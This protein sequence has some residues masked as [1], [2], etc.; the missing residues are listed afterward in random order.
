MYYTKWKD[1][2]LI[3]SV[4]VKPNR[5]DNHI[6]STNGICGGRMII[7]QMDKKSKLIDLVGNENV[8]IWIGNTKQEVR[9]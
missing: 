2:N 7:N 9:E 6:K 1:T 8:R 5:F 4:K 3:D